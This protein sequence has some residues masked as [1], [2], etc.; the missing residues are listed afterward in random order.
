MHV[1]ALA[2]ITILIAYR[3]RYK[4]HW[5]AYMDRLSAMVLDRSPYIYMY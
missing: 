5:A 3:L 4:A 2:A 1:S